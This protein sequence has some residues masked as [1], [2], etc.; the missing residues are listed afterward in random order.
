MRI[1]LYGGAFNPV[2]SEHV[3]VAQAAVEALE[4][5]KLIVIPTYVS[6]HKKGD[7][8]ARGKERA[9]MCRHAFACIPCAEVSTVELKRKGVSYSYVT[10][11]HFKKEYPDDDLFFIMGADMLECF[12]DWKEPEEILKCVTLAAAGREGE[13]DLRSLILSFSKKFPHSEVVPVGY[14]GS[15]VSSTRVRVLAALGEDL[16]DLVPEKVRSYI[17]HHDIYLMPKIASCRKYIK[18]KRWKHSVRVAILAAENCRRMGI[19]EEDAIIAGGLH[20]CAKY[21]SLD[22]PDLKGFICPPDVPEP[23]LH[24]FTG[25]YMAEH[26]FG[27]TDENILD[28]IR[29][30]TSGRENMAPLEKLLFLSDMLEEGRDFEGVD[31]LREVFAKDIDRCLYESLKQQVAYLESTGKP[32]YPLTK[33]AYDYIKEQYEQ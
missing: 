9:E 12:A 4:L 19:F 10:C 33:R 13:K 23:V 21:T 15:K 27:I 1:G 16:G 22:S 26:V 20:D 31:H 32:V 28:A 25:A 2:H 7:I 6:P 5:D 24:Q 3:R 18:E 17:R 11:R 14:T 8:M 30:H 29:Y